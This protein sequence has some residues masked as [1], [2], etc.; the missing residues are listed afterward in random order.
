MKDN[1]LRE[2]RFYFE[3]YKKQIKCNPKIAIEKAKCNLISMGYIN[4]NLEIQPPYNDDKLH[5]DDF[6]RGPEEKKYTKVN[7]Y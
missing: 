7:K 6:S 1:Y 5:D 4:S 2:M 3:M